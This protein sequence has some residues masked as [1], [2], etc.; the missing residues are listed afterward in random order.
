MHQYPLLAYHQ[1]HVSVSNAPD[2]FGACSKFGVRCKEERRMMEALVDTRQV[3][4]LRLVVQSMQMV[5]KSDVVSYALR[6]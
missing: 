4:D 5:T 1:L 2:G 3:V 6:T